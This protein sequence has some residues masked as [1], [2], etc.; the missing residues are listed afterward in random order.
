MK[1]LCIGNSFSHDATAFVNQVAKSAGEDITAVNLYIGGCSLQTHAENYGS[2]EK[3]YC[4]EINGIFGGRMVSL[5]EG[6]LDDNWDV[7]TIQQASHDSGIE[8]SYQPYGEFLL[9]KVRALKPNA[10]IYFHET[11][12]YEIN[13]EHWAFERYNKNQETMHRAITDCATK[14]S[15]ENNLDIIPSGEVIA[16]LRNYKE[17]NINLGG[18]SLCR[19]GFHMTFDCGRYAT[20]LTFFC[21]L[22][23]KSAF[24]TS[25]VPQIKDIIDEFDEKDYT[26]TKEKAEIIKS[27]VDKVLKEKGILKN[28]RI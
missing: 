15:K 27:T 11:W 12:A 6:I 7:I 25:F 19:D 28:E 10:K 24:E 21:T 20:A 4:Y 1:I 17:F 3:P 9:K 23:K 14:F 16:E 8:E 22:T 18:D 5:K 26:L 13:S 2:D